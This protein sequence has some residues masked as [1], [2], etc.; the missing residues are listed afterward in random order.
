MTIFIELS[1]ILGVATAI[2]GIMRLLRQPLIVG[3]IL[4]GIILGPYVFDYIQSDSTIE[5][6]SKIGITVLLFIV[7]LSLNPRAIKE[8]GKVSL[9]TG[10]GQVV[11]TS[12]IG[13]LLLQFLGYSIV[14][15]LYIAIALTFSSTIIIL[16]LLSDKG[17]TTKLY[18]KIAIGFL[19]VQDIIATVI[20]MFISS[21]SSGGGALNVIAV[22]MVKSILLISVMYFLAKYAI[23]R[24]SLFSAKSQEYLFLF[25]L[26]WGLCFASLF[27]LTGFSMEVGALLA[28]IFL[29]MTP[30]ALE[31]S[32]RL[33]PLRDFFIVLFFI[34]L[35][36]TMVFEGTTTSMVHTIILS[37]F[38]LVGNPYIVY[39]LMN[40]LNYAK[41]T[42]FFAGLTVAQISEFSMILVALGYS[43]GHVEKEVLSLVTMVG[44]IT[45]SVSTYMI[46]YSNRLYKQV[47]VVLSIFSLRKRS[48][49]GES[50][51]EQ[52]DIMLFGYNRVGQDFVK[53]FQKLGSSYIVIDFNPE[54][55]KKLEQNMLS[56]RYGDA[57][58]LEFLAEL[59]LEKTR[60]IVST[61]PDFDTNMLLVRSVRTVNKHAIIIPISDFIEHAN[62]LYE[63]GATYVAMPH[64]LGAQYISKMILEHH[65][66]DVQFEH[67]RYRHLDYLKKRG[68]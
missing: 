62:A 14:S 42:S 20:L 39:V 29:S 31:I 23:P 35:G 17:D 27:S 6:F 56:Y 65:L 63:A 52:F 34:G 67:E 21:I 8:V 1:V 64:Y 7:G 3:H 18:G 28:G 43:L 55:I 26:S 50:H 5:L 2:A 51:G 54:S 53:V 25:S 4:T 9:I 48:R 30:Y 38:V 37:I 12:V 11:F 68:N 41:R 57:Q 47:E 49:E 44:V 16:K 40:R 32:A 59:P 58:D 10:I 45:I 13:F 60:M 24:L 15:S 61:I 66:N 46:L 22:V 19:L 33:R 36:S